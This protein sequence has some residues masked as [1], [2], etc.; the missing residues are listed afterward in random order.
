MTLV[1]L[2][3]FRHAPLNDLA[4]IDQTSTSFT[5]IE[6]G[7]TNFSTKNQTKMCD[8]VQISQN[9]LDKGSYSLSMNFKETVAMQ[10]NFKDWKSGNARVFEMK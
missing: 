8:L 5:C 7:Y 6:T 1:S 10:V 2:P 3:K 4:I 9:M